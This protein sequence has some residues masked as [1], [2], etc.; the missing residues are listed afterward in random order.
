MFERPT[1]NAFSR[2]C[3]ANNVPRPLAGWSESEAASTSILHSPANYTHPV[4][5]DQHQHQQAQAQHLPHQHHLYAQQD[6]SYND[7]SDEGHLFA[8]RPPST[9]EHPFQPHQMQYSQHQLEHQHHHQQDKSQHQ[10]LYAAQL[11]N[12]VK[13]AGLSTSSSAPPSPYV[14][15]SVPESPTAP[16]PHSPHAQDHH[17]HHTHPPATSSSDEYEP[18]PNST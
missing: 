12:L 7:E 3:T 14:T 5:H 13:A 16:N 9:S 17:H 6:Q 8:Y 2:P 11:H 1:T 4:H 10:D 15:S 18:G